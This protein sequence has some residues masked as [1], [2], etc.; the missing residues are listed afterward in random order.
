MVTWGTSMAVQATCS[1]ERLL[2]S[3][4]MISFQ[5]ETSSST[6]IQRVKMKNRR[7]LEKR[8]TLRTVPI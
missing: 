1:V 4:T 7:V 3:C 8:V 2:V 6:L 5:L